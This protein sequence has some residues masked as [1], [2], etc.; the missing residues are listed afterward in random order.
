MPIIM[1]IMP[2]NILSFDGNDYAIS[3][4]QYASYANYYDHIMQLIMPIMP[5]TIIILCKYVR[6]VCPLC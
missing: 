2:F 3:A 1:L 6:I 4:H 5:I